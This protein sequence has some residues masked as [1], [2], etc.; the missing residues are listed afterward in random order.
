[1]SEPRPGVDLSALS[2]LLKQGANPMVCCDSGKNV[3]HD[4]FWVAKPPPREV[5]EAMEEVV[6]MLREATGELLKGVSDP[7]TL[8]VAVD[9]AAHARQ[10]HDARVRHS[11]VWRGATAVRR[12]HAPKQQA[13]E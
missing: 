13:E 10:A 4:M 6:R 7:S 11:K 8:K 2:I 5:L 9:T 1:M 12:A 3:L